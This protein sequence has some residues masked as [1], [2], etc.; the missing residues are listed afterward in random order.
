MEL[1]WASNKIFPAE[2]LIKM[3]VKIVMYSEAQAGSVGQLAEQRSVH[4]V[5]EK[6]ELAMGNTCKTKKSLT[7]AKSM[8][9]RT[10]FL[11]RKFSISSQLT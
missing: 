11:L 4:T 10:A 8:T 5:I 9:E 3:P 7:N 6:G 2:N 1:Y